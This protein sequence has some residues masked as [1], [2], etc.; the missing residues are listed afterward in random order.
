MGRQAETL[1]EA[2][3]GEPNLSDFRVFLKEYSY[4][5]RAPKPENFLNKKQS[6]KERADKKSL[7]SKALNP[8]LFR[9]TSLAVGVGSRFGV[10]DTLGLLGFLMFTFFF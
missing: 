1:D 10:S 9:G 6:D 5:S 7:G 2:S 4:S 8:S 3:V